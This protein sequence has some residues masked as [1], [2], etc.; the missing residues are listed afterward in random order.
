KEARV[1]ILSFHSLEDRIA[2]INFR[3]LAKTER[4]KLIVKKP[5]A[6]QPQEIKDNP[7][8]RSAKFRV[9]EKIQ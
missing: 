7:R 4:F 6:P 1:G 3:N 9:L 5:L 8:S 2:K